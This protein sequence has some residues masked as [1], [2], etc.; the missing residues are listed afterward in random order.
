[1]A[2]KSCPYCYCTNVNKHGVRNGKQ[3]Y[4]CQD[5]YTSWT[6]ISR[7]QRLIRRLWHDYAFEGRTV[8]QLAKAYGRS[9]TW[10]G[11][12]L[13][14]YEPCDNITHGR[15]VTV[16]MDVTYFGAWGVLVVI[17][18]YADVGKAESLVLYWTT[19]E[20]TERT[21]DYD[22]AT[23]TL[24][25]MG[26][27]VQAAVIDGRRGVRQ[28]LERKGI[29][30]QQCQFHQLQ[31]MTQCLTK[32]PKLPQNQELR[33]IA[34]TL[35]KTTRLAFE[36]RLDVWHE[37]HGEW[38]KER[39]QDPTTGRTRYQHDRTR[40]AYFSLR[41]NLPYLFTY[42]DKALTAKGINLPNT[43]NALDGRFGFWKQ[44]LKQHRGCSK[45]RKTTILRSLFSGRTD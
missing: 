12:Q 43:T 19:L 28:M 27:M 45:T 6:N 22:V 5:C 30:V 18:P 38:L 11:Q 42:Q 3:R 44:K 16:V 32:R 37:K 35:S 9:L 21:V 10:V 41:R 29:L 14:R 23:D 8:K 1:M 34:L 4:I 25:A 17:D 26:Y 2:R 15:K 20:G 33:S 40:R 13:D 39:H 36:A 7:K 31:T 24:E